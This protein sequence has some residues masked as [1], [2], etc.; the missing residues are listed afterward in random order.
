[1]AAL[2][3]KK[4]PAVPTVHQRPSATG[5]RKAKEFACARDSSDPPPGAR[6]PAT[7]TDPASQQLQSQDATGEQAAPGARQLGSP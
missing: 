3:K 7:G 4:R 2:E 1:M 5:K 6:R